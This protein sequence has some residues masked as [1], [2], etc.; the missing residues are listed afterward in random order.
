[1]NIVMKKDV[2][3][4]YGWY[5]DGCTAYMHDLQGVGFLGEHICGV[6]GEFLKETKDHKP[7]KT[8]TC[9]AAIRKELM[10]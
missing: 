5:C 1:M 7:I 2:K 6:T 9:F 4:P 3:V 10:K 8:N